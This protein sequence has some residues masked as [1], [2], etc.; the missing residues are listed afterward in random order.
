MRLVKRPNWTGTDGETV[1]SVGR[2]EPARSTGEIIHWVT[3][4]IGAYVAEHAPAAMLTDDELAKVARLIVHDQYRPGVQVVH[5]DRAH[6]FAYIRVARAQAGEVDLVATA[7]SGAGKAA[8]T[9]ITEASAKI[10]ELTEQLAEIR[11]AADLP[12]I[13]SHDE[14][15]IRIGNMATTLDRVGELSTDLLDAATDLRKTLDGGP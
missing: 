14:V 9:L 7:A 15:V 4:Q 11:R 8:A 3:D 2:G 12:E 1:V 6:L 5:L 13:M 10:A